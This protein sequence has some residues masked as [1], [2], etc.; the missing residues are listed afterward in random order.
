ML[1]IIL[2][3]I[4]DGKEVAEKSNKREI[5]TYFDI[6]RMRVQKMNLRLF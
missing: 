6:N 5:T 4:E 3:N 1:S 2:G